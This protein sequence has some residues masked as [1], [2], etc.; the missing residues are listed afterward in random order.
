MVYDGAFHSVCNLFGNYYNVPAIVVGD[1]QPLMQRV[2][3]KRKLVTISYL[4]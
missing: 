1:I 2:S 3:T 4:V